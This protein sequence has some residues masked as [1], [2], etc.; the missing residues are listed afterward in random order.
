MDFVMGKASIF[1]TLFIK[2]IKLLQV[3]SHF[4]PFFF[5]ARKKNAYPRIE[6]FVINLRKDP[7]NADYKV[8][9]VGFCWGGLHALT[10]GAGTPTAPP[11][12]D[13]VFVAHPSFSTSKEVA[14]VNVPL[15]LIIGD[16]DAVM[17]LSEVKKGE[18][19]LNKKS[20][21]HEIVIVPGAKHGFA[22]RGDPSDPKQA[23][24]AVQALN[25]ALAWFKKWIG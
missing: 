13:A 19:A 18:A 22:V 21:D 16:K 8:G 5:L 14:A 25:Q 1:A 4:I 20:D 9:T 17:S 7:A 24:F 6:N 10:L 3:L 12:V 11:L 2:P 23:D 15:S